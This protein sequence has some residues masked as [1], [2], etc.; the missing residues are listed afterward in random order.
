MHGMERHTAGKSFWYTLTRG[1]YGYGVYVRVNLSRGNVEVARVVAG[2]GSLGGIW[3]RCPSIYP[4][5]YTHTHSHTHIHTCARARRWW[6]RHE[7]PGTLRTPTSM[8]RTRPSTYFSG[9]RG[10]KELVRRG[11]VSSRSPT[12]PPDRARHLRI[13]CTYTRTRIARTHTRAASLRW[14]R[15]RGGVQ[16]KRRALI[17]NR[18]ATL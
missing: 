16:Q 7:H 1:N 3:P 6:N 9:Q 10:R 11:R 17:K 14:P 15:W 13:A 2:C 5:T 8:P 12:L 18:L 4:H